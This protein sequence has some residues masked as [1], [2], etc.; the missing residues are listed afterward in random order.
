MLKRVKAIYPG[1]IWSR[2]RG[3]HNQYQLDAVT[4]LLGGHIRVGLE[5]NLYIAPGQLAVDSAQFAKRTKELSVALGRGVASVEEA[6]KIL[7][8]HA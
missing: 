6:R 5:D 2:N 8:D 7:Q 4:I 3:A 1:S